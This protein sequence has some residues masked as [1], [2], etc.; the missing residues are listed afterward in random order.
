MIK[1][2]MLISQHNNNKSHTYNSEMTKILYISQNT[3][4]KNKK[5]GFVVENKLKYM[6]HNKPHPPP[7]KK[8]SN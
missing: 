4:K 5:Y 1:I 8:I 6:V 3:K 7:K 2:N